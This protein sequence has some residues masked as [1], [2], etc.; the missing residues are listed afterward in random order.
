MRALPLV[1]LSAAGLVFVWAAWPRAKVSGAGAALTW[2]GTP[3]VDAGLPG[4]DTSPAQFGLSP[5][6]FVDPGAGNDFF[7][8]TQLWENL[9]SGT[10]YQTSDA[11]PY[12]STIEETEL[13][14]GIPNSILYRLLYQESHF[15]P[16]IISG[17]TSSTTGALGIAQ[18]MPA[19]AAEL[20]VNPLDAFASIRAAGRYLASLY[21]RFGDWGLALA[22]YNWGQGNVSKAVAAGK[23]LYD[24]PS[25]TR[26]YVVAILQGAEI[27]SVLV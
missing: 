10:L 5:V 22:A 11:E 27:D 23:T 21:N 8:L 9:M 18:F 6:A 20:G 13:K 16:D 19:T 12:L 7:G 24:Y 14:F 15:R 2:S 4:F 25:E 26:A 1:L 17:Q 3:F